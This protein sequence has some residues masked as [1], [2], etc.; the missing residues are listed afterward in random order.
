MN[1]A[2]PCALPG[3]HKI[4]WIA[5]H[6]S[7]LMYGNKWQGLLRK[8]VEVG[9]FTYHYHAQWNHFST[10]YGQLFLQKIISEEIEKQNIFIYSHT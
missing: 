9:C 1:Y 2:F 4:I 3:P 8:Q 6:S 7:T 5:M 10:L